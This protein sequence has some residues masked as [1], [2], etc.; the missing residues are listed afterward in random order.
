MP[1]QATV[2]EPPGGNR[3]R[4]SSETRKP[5]WPAA[6]S[7]AAAMTSSRR[8]SST[9]PR[10]ASVTCI[11]SGLTRRSAGTSGRRANAADATSGGRATAT[12]RR[13]RRRYRTPA[14]GLMVWLRTSLLRGGRGVASRL[15]ALPLPLRWLEGGV[16]LVSDEQCEERE[17]Q[18][19]RER[20]E[21]GHAQAFA[22]VEPRLRGDH[23]LA[24]APA[25]KQPAC[26]AFIKARKATNR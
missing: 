6:A 3:P 18:D 10:K 4:L 17:P 21:D 23:E 24:H 26:R 14:D 11:R 2:G 7:A 15:G 12:K 19:E 22:A 25:N 13:T 1:S 8:A 20:G 5:G 16:R 9:V